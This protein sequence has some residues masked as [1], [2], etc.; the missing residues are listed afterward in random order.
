MRKL[1][2]DLRVRAF[3]RLTLTTIGMGLLVFLT[4]GTLD[5]G[6]AWVFLILFYISSALIF[7]YLWKYDVKLL[8]RRLHVGPV[9]EV[10]PT[11]KIIVFVIALQFILMLILSGLD[12]HFH[13]RVTSVTTIAAGDALFLIGSLGIF[14]VF[15]ANSYAAATVGLMHGQ[16]IIST[17][18]YA[19]I[20]HPMYFWATFYLT[21]IPLA[22]GSWHGFLVVLIMIPTLIWRL[23]D[24][25]TFLVRHLSGYTQY[26]MKVKRRLIPFVW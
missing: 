14:F 25:E 4:A 10:T 24:E 20:R 6:Q 8:E 19:I 26:K 9:A 23:I 18:P 16:K 3:L 15:R 7:M 1:L 17:G 5:F 22:L 12:Y 11:Q 13:R 21:G 2:Q